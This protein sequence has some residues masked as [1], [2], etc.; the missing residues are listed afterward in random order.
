MSTVRLSKK[1]ETLMERIRAKYIL[2]G[3]KMTKKDLLGQLIKK[4][5]KRIEYTNSSA[6]PVLEQDIAWQLL[7][8]PESWGIRDT[9]VTVDDFLY[10]RKGH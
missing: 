1:D 7:D 4:E 8:K 9:S 3:K 6:L 5:A 2:M 10:R